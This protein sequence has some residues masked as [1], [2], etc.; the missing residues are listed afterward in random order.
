MEKLRNFFESKWAV[1]LAFVPVVQLLYFFIA[2]L[3]FRKGALWF[4]IGGLV[5]FF[6]AGLLTH[7][8]LPWGWLAMYIPLTV[9]AL[10]SL[11][12]IRESD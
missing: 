8:L 3:V 12:I 9:L 4:R 6:S 1:L 5:A 11:K 2:F 10:A 7:F